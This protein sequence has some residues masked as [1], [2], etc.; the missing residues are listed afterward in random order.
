MNMDL[1][2]ASSF[3]FQKSRPFTQASYC[4]VIFHGGSI[5]V[6]ILIS[7]LLLLILS[8]CVIFPT[9]RTYFEPNNDDGIATRSVSCGYN[10]TSL[11]SLERNINEVNFKVTP[12]YED[13]ELFYV[14]ISIK[15]KNKNN[16]FLP[17]NWVLVTQNPKNKYTPKLVG[18]TSQ[19]PRSNWPFY[20]KWI[21][22]IYPVKSNELN[23][24]AIEFMPDSVFLNGEYTKLNRFRFIKTTK[25]DIYYGSINC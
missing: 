24:I 13:N 22:V 2:K 7:S 3:L 18:I 14:S 15:S 21:N 12:H 19:Q 1:G 16:K 9:T 17:D 11:D 8:S 5:R 20:V 4:G 10:R 25:S 23:Q 6:R